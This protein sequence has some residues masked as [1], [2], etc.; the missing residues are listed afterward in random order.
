MSAWLTAANKHRATPIISIETVSPTVKTLTFRDKLCAKAKPGQFLMLWVPG[1]DE[2]PLSV[3]DV[4]REDAKVSVVVKRV[5]EAT[6]ALHNLK[7][8]DWIGVRGPFG[9]SFTFRRGK[10]LLVGGGVGIAPLVFLAKELAAQKASETIVVVGAKT[11]DELIFMDK[12]RD[13]CE[14]ENVLVATENGSYGLKGLASTLAESVMAKE[15]LDIVYTCGPEPMT[16]AA[17]DCAEKFGVYAEASLERIMRCA[18]GICGSCVIGGFRVCKEGPIFN[19]NQLKAVKSEFGVW[20]RDFN[21]K[22]VPV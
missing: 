6:R 7:A 4:D 8:G 15:K 20:K 19:I 1:V 21:G 18:I 13:F 9:N 10:A 17:L 16:R 3:F 11:R 22:R 5:G 2:I 14:E 12:L